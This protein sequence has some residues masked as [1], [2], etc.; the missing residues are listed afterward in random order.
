MKRPRPLFVV[1][2]TTLAL[3]VATAFPAP[4]HAAGL[5]GSKKKDKAA[6]EDDD[7]GEIDE[8]DARAK[9]P[10]IG[11]MTQIVGAWWIQ[12]EGAGLVVDLNGTGEDP[13][14]SEARHAVLEDLKRR[15]VPNPNKILKLPNVTVVLITGYVPALIRKGEHFDLEIRLPDGSKVK[16]LN[17]GRLMP[18]YLREH[19]RD[20]A[21]IDHRS[22]EFAVAEGPI[23]VGSSQ[24][25]TADQAGVLRRG[26]IVGGGTWKYE[27][28][29]LDL[30]V[31][32][33]F[34]SER[35]TVRIANAIGR[36]FF[37][38]DKH[39]QRIPLAEAKT[40]QKIVLKVMPKYRDNYPRYLELIRK[41]PFRE[42]DV[43]RSVRIRAL[44]WD[45]LE[46]ET[47]AQAAL[48]LEAIGEQGIPTLKIGLKS[49]DPQV[50]FHSAEALA[51]LG[52]S[53]GLNA[54]FEAARDQYAFRI[55]ALAAMACLDDPE[56][57]VKLRDLMDVESAETRYGAFRALTTLDKNDPFVRG[58]ML[59]KQFRLHTLKTEGPPMV[60]ITNCKKAEVVL[61]GSD[62]QVKT[63][64]FARAGNNVIVSAP[65][66]SDRVTVCRFEVGHEDQRQIVPN[67]LQDVIRV[68]TELGATFP[69]VNQFLVEADH[70]QNLPG[71]LEIDALP[72]AGRSYEP[73]DQLIGGRR[74]K[75][76]NPIGNAD[77]A[78]NMFAV[79]EDKKA[80]KK[81]EDEEETGKDET[82]HADIA[83][84]ASKST[85]ADGDKPASG[86]A[87]SQK[88]ATSSGGAATDPTSSVKPA[89]QT[90]APGSKSQVKTASHETDD[91]DA[92]SK[93]PPPSSGWSFWKLFKIGGGD[94]SGNK[95]P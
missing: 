38:Y 63:P 60:H 74:A 10:L 59:G 91:D 93:S 81:G 65:P 12:L 39:G 18:T 26:R 20:P 1:W 35:N 13:P 95:E 22:H 5:F 46:P 75:R 47:S 56:V 7:S 67:R 79:G 15:G 77:N 69:D 78:P 30:Y 61:F 58:E 57:H 31:R 6:K 27:N 41:I 16:S 25:N 36:R 55:F 17:G 92:P 71:R 9:V 86:A 48:K 40:D 64:L 84:K 37:D 54:L 53:T 44:K 51:Y 34:R 50:R 4:G 68:M 28:R 43:A 76:K 88:S 2:L 29:D 8:Y 33:E 3:L 23:L 49:N 89:S 24:K 87:A 70:Q 80:K 90:D 72:R 85:D 11:E 42:T 21:G 14:P 62:Q 73:P 82:S 83:P 32:N 19:L 52:D 94:V 45:L 66:G